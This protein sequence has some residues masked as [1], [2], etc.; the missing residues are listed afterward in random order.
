LS[1]RAT[2]GEKPVST[3]NPERPPWQPRK[4]DEPEILNPFER[5]TDPDRLEEEHRDTEQIDELEDP[6]DPPDPAKASDA[7][8]VVNA[9]K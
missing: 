7:E 8:T 9:V 2:T 1:L 6:E 4:H 5:N 3:T